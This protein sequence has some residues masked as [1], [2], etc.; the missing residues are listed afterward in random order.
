MLVYSVPLLRNCNTSQLSAQSLYQFSDNLGTLSVMSL[1]SKQ[2][3]SGNGEHIVLEFFFWRNWKNSMDF[4]SPKLHYF[5]QTNKS[6]IN[7]RI[8]AK[9]H[10]YSFSLVSKVL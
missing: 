10:V 6:S 4:F 2:G 8:E 7:L 5:L 9:E 3:Y 1:I